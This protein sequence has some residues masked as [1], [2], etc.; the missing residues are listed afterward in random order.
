[1]KEIIEQIEALRNLLLGKITLMMKNN[2]PYF[3]PCQIDI[4]DG[5]KLPWKDERLVIISGEHLFM[6]IDQPD[7]LG[8]Y[9]IHENGS[10][11]FINYGGER[12]RA[13][14][15]HSRSKHIFVLFQ[16]VWKEAIYIHECIENLIENYKNKP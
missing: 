6:K 15:W 7:K 10:Y 12:K 14:A 2:D 3:E 11:D 8:K 5:N 9:K 1:L 4:N 13:T 16:K